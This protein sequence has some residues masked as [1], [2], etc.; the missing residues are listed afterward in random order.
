MDEP[1]VA[2]MKLIGR[3][4]AQMHHALALESNDVA[5]APEPFDKTYRR[6]VFQDIYSKTRRILDQLEQALPLLTP[7]E[8]KLAE[9]TLFLRERL[10]EVLH[11]FLDTSMKGLKTRVHGE[12]DLHHLLFTGRQFMI[13]D[14]EGRTT[15][16]LSAR[17]LKRSPLRDVCDLLSSLTL[18][19]ESALREHALTRPGD[20]D[21]LRHWAADWQSRM[22]GHFLR[23]YLENA[24]AE[25]FLPN[26][27]EHLQLILSTF[28]LDQAFY[29]LSQALEV[30]TGAIVTGTTHSSLSGILHNICW[31]LSVTGTDSYRE[32]SP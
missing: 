7:A 8:T 1:M 6:A 9:Q 4:T 28:L 24:D 13:V 2:A 10:G 31:L 5:F 22:G 23:S 30:W 25:R 15:R 19:S 21:T 16:S 3:M 32:V 18:V 12:Y 17:R 11:T 14:F 20:I 27:M 29:E 26:N